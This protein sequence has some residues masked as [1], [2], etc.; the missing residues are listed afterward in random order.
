M[1]VEADIVQLRITQYTLGE[2]V[3]DKRIRIESGV[4]GEAHKKARKTLD[5]G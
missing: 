5:L 4:C 2:A 3:K 1:P